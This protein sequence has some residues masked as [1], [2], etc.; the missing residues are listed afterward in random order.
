[1]KRC[2]D[3]SLGKMLHAYELGRL[4]QAD[5][6]HYEMH[7]LECDACFGEVATFEE[8]TSLLRK[9]KEVQAAIENTLASLRQRGTILSKLLSHLWPDG[10]VWQRPAIAYL[11][12][13]L[14]MY[15]AYLGLSGSISSDIRQIQVLSLSGLR[16][17]QEQVLSAG[18]DVVIRFRS[19]G[20]RVGETYKVTIASVETGLVF[21][22]SL[23][24]GFDLT[25]TA[26]LFFPAGWLAPGQY[27]VR[28]ENPDREPPFNRQE[29]TFRVM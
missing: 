22:D 1:M 7:M 23:F 19:H 11:A 17:S 13:V 2:T 8:A 20:A 26:C 10:R 21:S 29:Y 9:D 12:I 28:I 25:E 14:L 27:T 16:S 5:Q 4:S 6:D 3:S 15:P 24:S 18:D